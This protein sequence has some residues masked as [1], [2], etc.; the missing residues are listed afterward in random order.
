MP[1]P[2]FPEAGERVFRHIGVEQHQPGQRDAQVIPGFIGE[3]HQHEVLE[4]EGFASQ[5]R[6]GKA[7]VLRNAVEAEGDGRVRVGDRDQAG[8]Q[9]E[10]LGIVRPDDVPAQLQHFQQVGVALHMGADPERKNIRVQVET[11]GKIVRPGIRALF[12]AGGEGRG[13]QGQDGKQADQPFH[14]SDYPPEIIHRHHLSLS[15]LR[16]LWSSAPCTPCPGEAGFRCSR[17]R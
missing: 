12:R 4:P 1:V 10:A 14:R 11:K 7:D 2:Y 16:D 17:F 15:R 8:V 13:R 5:Q 3:F 9:V 6:G